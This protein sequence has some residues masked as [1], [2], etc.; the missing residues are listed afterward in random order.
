L[1]D[2][3]R[4]RKITYLQAARLYRQKLES[5]FPQAASNDLLNEYLTYMAVVGERIDKK[6]LTEAEAEYELARKMSELRDRAVVR[7]AT[8]RQAEAQGLNDPASLTERE[9]QRLA[10]EREL[11]ERRAAQ[12][13]ALAQQRE[14]AAQIADQAERE[15]RMRESQE[16]IAAGLQLLLGSRVAPPPAP[17]T[18][19]WIGPNWVCQ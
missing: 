19:R 17:V 6:K 15:R 13:R 14:L 10:Q 12:E 1:L 16:M 3:A 7:E 9:Q 5:L 11:A 18:C 2:Q 4:N 8:L